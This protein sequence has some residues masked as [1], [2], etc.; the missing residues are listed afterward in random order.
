VAEKT[1]KSPDGLEL[2]STPLAS[3]RL[4]KKAALG[5]VAVVALVLGVVIINV[6]KGKTAK[7]AESTG[8][9]ELQ[10]ALNAAQDLTKDVPDF[11]EPPPKLEQPP[12]P[13]L[14]PGREPGKSPED[15]ARLADT[16][17]GK[18]VNAD[19]IGTGAG[20]EA[21]PGERPQDSADAPGDAVTGT[22]TSA[23]YGGESATGRL[24]RVAEQGQAGESDLNHQT[25][26][27]EFQQKAQRGVYLNSQ[28]KAP[29]SAFE[30]KTGTVIP[31]TLISAVNSDLPGEII[32]QV[33]QNVYDTATGKY[34]LI[35]QGSRL[36]GHYDSKVSFGQSRALVSWQR[37]I[38][39]NAYTLEL[40]GMS[41][42]DESGES[43]FSDQVNNHYARIFGWALLTSVMSAGAQLSQPQQA[44]SLVP[45]NSQV[46][47]AAVGQQMSQLGA[48]IA[49]RNLQV[50]PTIEIRKGY[51]LEVMV[52][53]DII[54][55]DSYTP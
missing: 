36:F 35:P 37:L 3:A 27:L 30:L 41:G 11:V 6:S 55:P 42:H 51:R 26:K 40:G 15:D 16:A 31:A 46:A 29:V 17:V 18:F 52:N 44:G 43:G 1:L 33:A 48:Q 54:F 8:P 12:P 21:M 25:E 4:S 7:A 14:P 53:R 9:R 20:T 28:L 10:P 45:S 49:S 32:A 34:L 22:N 38:Y 39:P 47:A 50:Q 2:R 13:S 23:A 24:L 19:R 5:A